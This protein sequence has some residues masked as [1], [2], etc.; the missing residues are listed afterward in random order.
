MA[1]VPVQPVRYMALTT[2]SQKELGP[3][4][5]RGSPDEDVADFLNNRKGTTISTWN[6]LEH[7]WASSYILCAEVRPSSLQAKN[8]AMN[9]KWNAC[10][11]QSRTVAKP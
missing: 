9:G 4:R 7:Q 10:W 2:Y 6:P 1:V 11:Y 3:E 5:A 8:K